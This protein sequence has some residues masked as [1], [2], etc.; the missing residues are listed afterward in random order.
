MKRRI[1]R[2]SS[3][4][5]TEQP[6]GSAVDLIEF[7]R[8]LPCEKWTVGQLRSMVSVNPERIFIQ[9]TK[10]EVEVRADKFYQ[11]TELLK[12]PGIDARRIDEFRQAGLSA[13]ESCRIHFYEGRRIIALFRGNLK[14]LD[15]LERKARAGVFE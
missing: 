2:A 13:A 4:P 12:I 11:H 1:P 9:T 7:N 8:S 5:E 15:L 10:G 6:D 3:Q 14:A